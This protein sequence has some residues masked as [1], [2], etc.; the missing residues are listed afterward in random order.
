MGFFKDNPNFIAVLGVGLVGGLVGAWLASGLGLARTSATSLSPSHQNLV[1]Q[2]DSAVVSVVDKVSPAVV[3]ITF[4]ATVQGFF[5]QVLQ[6]QGGG[7]GFI[8][9]KDGLIMTNRHVVQNQNDLEVTTVEGKSYKAKVVAID[10]LNDFALIKIEAANLPIVDFGDTSA[11][12]VGQR[13][14]A[15]GN[16]LGQYQNTVT[17]GVVSAIGRVITA[18]DG[19]GS[20][21]TID[22]VIQ[23]DASINPGNS[24]GP[25]INLA[26]QVIGINTA[27]DTQG[28][29][30]GF[31]IPIEVAKTGLES[32]L[33]NGK[34]VRPYLGI[35]YL[36]ISKELAA[37]ENLPV[38]HG[39]L[40]TTDG[41]Q[42][43][44]VS[45]GGPAARA[46]LKEGD[47]ILSINNEAIEPGLGLVSILQKHSPNETVN[48]EVLRDGKKQTISVKLGEAS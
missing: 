36:N 33:K 47:I 9:S 48:L 7:T 29:E 25:L 27:V 11:L 26:G 6:Q 42:G 1:V 37:R 21:E 23:T 43:S 45:A 30:I 19:A 16:A 41:G 44:P 2:E 15:I 14:I 3:S 46:G 28:S 38:D 32:Y 40:V 10:S 4:H 31:A 5:G 13:V 35:R 39:A 12:K 24:G 22:N 34:I 8:V 20:T 18:G 17:S